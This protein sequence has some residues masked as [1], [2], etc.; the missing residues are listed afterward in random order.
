MKRTWLWLEGGYR[1]DLRRIWREMNGIEFVIGYALYLPS[2]LQLTFYIRKLSRWLGLEQR[3]WPTEG[4]VCICT[5]LTI[6]NWCLG[7]TLWGNIAC[8]YF[9]ASTLITLLQVVFLH[10]LFG[11]MHST[12]RSMI[13]LL[14]NVVQILF[15]YAAWYQL[16]TTRPDQDILLHTLFVFA[17][18]GHPEHVPHII[19]E[20]QIATNFV[21]LVV[22]LNHL[23]SRWA[24]RDRRY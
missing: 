19:I 24:P 8:S 21:L 10:R 9:S 6:L 3:T 20:L 15:M 22:F 11:E 7:P 5:V 1:E 16:E 17:T 18:I 13:L 4:Y 12:H 2:V 23:V 14:L